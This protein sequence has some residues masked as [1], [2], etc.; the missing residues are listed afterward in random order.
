MDQTPPPTAEELKDSIKT[1]DDTEVVGHAAGSERRAAA[2]QRLARQT[3][4]TILVR[5]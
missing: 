4:T 2:E 3:P 1:Y 5:L